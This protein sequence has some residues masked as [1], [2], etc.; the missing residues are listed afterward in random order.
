M[1]NSKAEILFLAQRAGHILLQNGAEITRVEVTM[2]RI[3]RHYGVDDL[4]FFILSNGI[5]VSG[6]DVDGTKE[7]A[8]VEFIP[9]KGASL[10][11]VVEVNQLSRQI[12]QG[13]YTVK[14]AIARLDEIE[15][16][17]PKPKWELCLGSGLGSVGFCAI[18]SG[19]MLDC[20]A[21]FV[22]GVLLYVVYLYLCVPYMSKMLSNIA[23]GAVASLLC[24]LFWK[25]GFGINLS[26]MMIG[27]IIPLVPGVA[28]TN[29]IRDFAAEDYISGATRLL[30]ALTM[31][32]CIAIGVCIT[33]YVYS[34]FT[35]GM[36][37]L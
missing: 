34:R 30:D 8:N 25:M 32:I 33:L 36:L 9:I 7:Y 28:F 21:S 37:P 31:F 17:K 3:A 13:K 19:G 12:E 29:G 18:F 14:E 5:F 27:A 22:V 16:M 10:D 2:K 15:A 24:I 26:P 35:G 1:E 23:G 11:K 20:A 6:N 4:N